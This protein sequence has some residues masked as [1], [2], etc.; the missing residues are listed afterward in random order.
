MTIEQE[1]A[2]LTTAVDNLTSAVN[3]KKATL[4][5]SVSDAEGARDTAQGHATTA[6]TER[7]AAEAAATS[8]TATAAGLTG[9]D[10]SAIDATLTG[11]AVDVSVYDTSRDSDGGAWRKR[12]QGDVPAV[13][14]LQ[15]EAAQLVAFDADQT[16]P[17]AWRTW[18]LSSYTVSSV[19]AGEGRV[20][21]G[22][23]AG[24]IELDMLTVNTEVP[25]AYSTATASAIVNNAVN[26][27]A[28]TVL[29]DAPV[30][31]ATGLPV[32]TIAVATDGG[33]SVIR[34]DGTVVDSSKG[35]AATD[36]TMDGGTLRVA[37]SDGDALAYDIASITADGFTGTALDAATTPALLGAP[38]SLALDALGSASGMSL[39]AGADDMVAYTTSTYNT[40]WM[41]GD[42]KGA[43]LS[44]TDPI[45]LVGGE[46]VTNGDASGGLTGWTDT[47]GGGGSAA[48]SGGVFELT[49][50]AAGVGGRI[51]QDVATVVG[52]RYRLSLNRPSGSVI[53]QA[54][55]FQSGN[56]SGDLVHEFV[57]TSA[58]SRITLL[59]FNSGS[60]QVDNVSVRLADADRSVNANPLTV[61]GTITR[62]PVATGAELVAYGGFSAGVNELTLT[63]ASISDT[64]YGLCWV[65]VSGVWELQHGVMSTSPIEGVTIS[66]T[67][68]TVAGANPKALLRL[69]A[70]SPSSDQIAK[71]YED[72]K[73]L[74]Q[75]NAACTLYGTSDAVTALAHDSVTDLLHVGTSAGRSDFQGLRRVA[76]TTDPITAAISAHDGLII[77]E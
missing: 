48:V 32:P 5:A 37:F 62:S 14:V 24:L 29:P 38:S 27:V 49:S 22:A 70:T 64:L 57:A 7:L 66:G 71:I 69:T 36:A 13:I 11:T 34:D 12:V 47:S 17:S 21:I 68:L 31:S 58:T 10:L 40:G 18:D 51:Y 54:P 2:N 60:G 46:L 42:I 53:A 1:V 6:N 72:E 76:N 75:E 55:G 28:M 61:N 56:S 26:D 77:E 20:W 16:T 65:Q 73:A 44:D 15:L 52:Q 45:D 19:T 50:V 41:N 4:D 39:L 8:A 23:T 63:D 30:D 74:F 9:F 67:A 35:T 25:L 33:V 43:F 3:V 59:R